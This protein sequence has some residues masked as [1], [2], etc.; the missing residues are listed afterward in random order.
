M[1]SCLFLLLLLF[2]AAGCAVIWYLSDS[3]EFSR[4]G[5]ASPPKAVP[6]PRSR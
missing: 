2:I 3:A 4:K 1:K 6:V 5:S